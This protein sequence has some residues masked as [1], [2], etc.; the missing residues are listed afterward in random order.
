MIQV[1]ELWDVY[2][3]NRNP[4]GRLHRR[5]VRLKQGEFHIIC[6][7]WIT[8]RGRLLVTQRHPDKNFGCMWECTGGAVIAGEDS[9][10]AVIREIR[11]EIGV[12][13]TEDQLTFMGS[14]AGNTFFVDCYAVELDLELSELKLQREEVVSAK[15]VTLPEFLKMQGQKK[16]IPRLYDYM[17]A[18]DFDFVKE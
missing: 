12:T 11:E 14:A 9:R 3:E 8:C 13:V 1:A 6:E 10:Q 5:G 16:I 17:K 4:V 7:A 18:F 2:D 15:F